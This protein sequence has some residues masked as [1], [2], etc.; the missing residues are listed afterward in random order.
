MNTKLRT[1]AIN[2]FEREFFKLMNN[3][4]F[5]KTM[6]NVRNHRDIKLVTTNER[7]NELVSERNYHAT[8]HFSENLLAI[9]MRKSKVVL[10]KPIYLGQA[11]LDISKTLMYEFFMTILNQSMGKKQNYVIWTRIVLLC[12]LRLKIFIKILLMMLKNGLVHLIMTNFKDELGGKIIKEF[13][14][15]RAKTYSFKIDDGN[16]TE[17]KKA[18]GTKKCAIKRRLK[19][20]DYYDSIFENKNILISKQ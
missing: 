5:G 17:N 2:D 3:S 7:R 9:E 14:A 11:I 15:P 12:M 4:F 18:K 10:S 1:E 6:E 13:C 20:K 8:K 16:N 19:F